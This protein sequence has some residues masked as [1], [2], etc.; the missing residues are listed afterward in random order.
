MTQ[1]IKDI[2]ISIFFIVISLLAIDFSIFGKKWMLDTQKELQT[3]NVLLQKELVN[4]RTGTTAVV[5]THM[6]Q[7]EKETFKR[8]DTFNANLNTNLETVAA[9]TTTIA[10]NT[11]T[12]TTEVQLTAGEYRTLR[13]D[14]VDRIK[15]FDP[16][17]DCETND[18]CWQ[19]LAT[20]TMIASRDMSINGSKSFNEI[21]RNVPLWTANTNMISNSIAL[22]V[23]KFVEN[24]AQISEN[25]NKITKPKWYDRILSYGFSGALIYATASAK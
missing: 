14:I 1:K 12:L 22:N 10:N 13:K 7:I 11:T 15:L 19:N 18:F 23:P 16:Q 3:T 24:T 17:F 25:I 5:D 6:A 20:D 8:L 4:W 2:S 9:N 21:S